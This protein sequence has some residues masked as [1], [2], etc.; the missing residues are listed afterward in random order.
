MN[1]GMICLKVWMHQSSEHY[2]KFT[3]IYMQ[4]YNPLTY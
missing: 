3:E 2:N 1:R 4:N